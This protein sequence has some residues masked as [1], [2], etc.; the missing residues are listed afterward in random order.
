MI[1]GGR[2]IPDDVLIATYVEVNVP[3]DRLVLHSEE[4]DRYVEAVSQKTTEPIERG[5]TLQRV[6]T[7]RKMGRLPRLRRSRR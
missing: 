2:M 7:L 3:A 4:G 5:V 6:I 1:N